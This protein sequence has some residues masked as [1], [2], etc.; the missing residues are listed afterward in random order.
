[1][2]TARLW[3]LIGTAALAA[4]FLL[5]PRPLAL[6]RKHVLDLELSLVPRGAKADHVVM[7]EIVQTLGRAIAREI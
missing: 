4:V 6:F 7:S 2:K 1:M 3:G 5:D